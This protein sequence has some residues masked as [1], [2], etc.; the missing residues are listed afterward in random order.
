MG[1]TCCGVG[2]AAGE[3]VDRRAQLCRVASGQI[4]RGTALSGCLER[5]TCAENRSKRNECR[6]S[7]VLAQ[8]PRWKVGGAG[9]A[10]WRSGVSSVR[11]QGFLGRR[12]QGKGLAQRWM[13]QASINIFGSRHGE[14]PALK[15]PGLVGRRRVGWDTVGPYVPWAESREEA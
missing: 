2:T 9:P 15:C 6:G 8:E 11:A 4:A 14:V 12:S 5:S 13:K 10:V 7:R 3:Q 1:P